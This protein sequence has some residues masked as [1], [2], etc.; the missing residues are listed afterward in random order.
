MDASALLF[1]NLF[2]FS[3]FSMDDSFFRKKKITTVVPIDCAI[4]NVDA[5]LPV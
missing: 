1:G 2:L 3:L 4:S 5:E